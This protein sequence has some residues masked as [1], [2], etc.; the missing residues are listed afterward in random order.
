MEGERERE[1][2]RGAKVEGSLKSRSFGLP[3][4]FLSPRGLETSPAEDVQA[5]KPVR[6]SPLLP[7]GIRGSL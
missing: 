7:F 1:S 3:L 6:I 2:E 5:G 4:F